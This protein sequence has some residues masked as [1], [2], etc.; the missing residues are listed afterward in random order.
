M[1]WNVCLLH[2]Y[3]TEPTWN[4]GRYDETRNRCCDYRSGSIRSFVGCASP[5]AG[6]EVSHLRRG[7]ALLA[8][9]AGRREPQIPGVCDEHRAT[10][11]RLLI[12]RVVSAAWA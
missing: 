11:V 12:P 1:A 6:R 2:R 4:G 5:C 8:Q 10:K 7:N 9:Y 3:R